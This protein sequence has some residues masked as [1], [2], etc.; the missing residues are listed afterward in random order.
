[1]LALRHTLSGLFIMALLSI[2]QAGASTQNV[3]D[4]MDVVEDHL[5]TRASAYPGTPSITVSAPQIRQQASCDNLEVQSPAGQRLRSRMTVTVRCSAPEN[6]SL[7][8]QAEVSVEGYYYVSN[9]RLNVGEIISLDDLNPREGDI[10]RL[11][12]SVVTDPSHIIGFMAGQRIAAGSMIKASALRDPQSVLR[13][14]TVRTIARGH[15]FMVS[16]EGQT[17]QA[18]AP[19]SQVQVRVGAGNVITATVLDS[20]TVQVLM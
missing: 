6:W 10:L 16:S 4:V 7:H 1:M 15:G 20:S 5:Y 18:G 3:N 13:G 17:L 12:S 9:R 11:A 14:Q 8:V 2:S 19:G